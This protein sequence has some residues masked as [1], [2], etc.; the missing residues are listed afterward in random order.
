MEVVHEVA[1]CEMKENG[2]GS[3][4]RIRVD[5]KGI[6]SSGWQ[7]ANSLII[8][9]TTAQFFVPSVITEHLLET[10]MSVSI[11]TVHSA[12]MPEEHGVNVWD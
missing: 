5:I 7:P 8:S 12:G 4:P 10:K 3:W 9:S 6:M 11:L 2:L 1:E